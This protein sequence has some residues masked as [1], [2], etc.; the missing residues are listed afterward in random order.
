MWNHH[1]SSNWYPVKKICAVSPPP[2]IH[3]FCVVSPPPNLVLCL[4]HF[5]S[6]LDFEQN[7]ESGKFQLERWSQAQLVS[8]SVALLA[9]L[10]LTFA[11][12][13]F[14]FNLVERWDGYILNPPSHP[15]THFVTLELCN[16]YLKD[17]IFQLSAFSTILNILTIFNGRWCLLVHLLANKCLFTSTPS[18]YC[19]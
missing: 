15:P 16:R 10:V 7:W 11:K 1:C 5:S 19:Q 18:S 17:F 9:E 13:I 8:S 14:Y 6:V 4:E 2:G 3:F 12:L